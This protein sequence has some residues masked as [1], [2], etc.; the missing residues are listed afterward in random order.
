MLETVAA[1]TGQTLVLTRADVRRWLDPGECIDA[2]E[3]AF[4][5]HG[6]GRTIAPAVL[7]VHVAQGGFHIKTAGVAGERS[8]FATKINANYPSNRERNGLPTIQ[9]V[10]A[11]FDTATG[12][13]RAVLDSIE[14]TSQRTAAATAVAARHLARP[15][16]SVVTICGCG[17]QGRSQ[18]RALTHVR[19]LRTVFAHDVDSA[20]AEQY[21]EE[22]AAEFGLDVQVVRDL[23]QATR[24][25]DIVVTCT[26]SRRA[27]ITRD[28][29]APGTFVAGVGA[30][31]E[32]K[33]ELEPELL[34]GSTVVADVLEQ[35]ASIGDL[36]HALKRGL[37][38]RTDVYAE[39]AEIVAGS[40][41]GRRT[42]DE[43]IVFDSTG[44]AL[45]DV[46]AAAIVYERALAAGSA[47]SFAL[48]A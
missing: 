26:P 40:K 16:S 42:T 6:Q 4:R 29:I 44:T 43:I 21:R 24:R 47:P 11:L 45:Q 35:C 12:S 23:A 27:F 8:Y 33:Q 31:A 7:G 48:G 17:E 41:P 38:Q 2:V 13:V 32:G 10:I 18:L 14:I 28:M 36:Q 37:M 39:L 46:A 20:R 15:D 1:G 9:G 25:S 19:F 30:D 34:A 3:W 5:M 22:M